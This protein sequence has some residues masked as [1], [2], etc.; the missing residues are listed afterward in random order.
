M[1]AGKPLRPF[2][3]IAHLKP[4]ID[5]LRASG[6]TTLSGLAAALTAKGIPT[7][8]MSAWGRCR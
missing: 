7:T 2:C 4:T 6:V 3:D 1:L 8:G 5:E